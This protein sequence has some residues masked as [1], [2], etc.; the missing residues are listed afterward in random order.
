MDKPK[1]SKTITIKIN[2][3]ESPFI[4]KN[5]DLI[6]KE[7][8]APQ[9]QKT[10]SINPINEEAAAAKE[11][12]DEDSFEWILPKTTNTPIIE[13]IKSTPDSTKKKKLIPNLTANNPFKVKKLPL[14]K[15]SLSTFFSVF[16]AVLLG[17]FFGLMLLK[18]VPAE[19][20]VEN[21]Q[22][23]VNQG[24][25]T[26]STGEKSTNYGTLTATRQSLTAAV[27]QEG[28]YST[29]ESAAQ[30]KQKLN[31]KGTPAE[32]FTSDGQFALF[33]GVS[34]QVEEAKSIGNGLKAS[35]VDTYSKQWIVGEKNLSNLHDEE[36]KLLEIS[37]QIFQSIVTSVS[38]TNGTNKI[39]QELME[40][41][42]Q[43]KAN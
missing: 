13:D 19:K 42:N 9:Q 15:L 4:E 29:K 10:I 3:K 5:K 7:K 38:S 8:I 43:Q 17:T 36:K 22:P 2:G 24:V 26:P 18:I 34:N 28:I 21:D 12:S 1:E 31:D 25:E 33:V 6:E 16:F 23:V 32:V 41:V 37:P 40:K 20:V 35:G 11:Q 14:K 30:I 27:V 39:P